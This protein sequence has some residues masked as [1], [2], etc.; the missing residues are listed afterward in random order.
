MAYTIFLI[1][2]AIYVIRMH[3]SLRPS[4][5][6]D[7]ILPQLLVSTLGKQIYS[8]Q[9]WFLPHIFVSIQTHLYQLMT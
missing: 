2:I 1:G 4:F 5:T 6:K 3:L 9:L 8:L 7:Y